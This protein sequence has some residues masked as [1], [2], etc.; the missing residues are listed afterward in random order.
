MASK[1]AS[2]DKFDPGFD[3]RNLITLISM[4]IL[5]ITVIFMAFEAIVTS[6]WPKRSNLTS[7]FNSVMSILYVP[8]RVET[9]PEISDFQSGPAIL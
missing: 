5:F 4:Y 9:D 3:I 7:V 2:E 8:A 1:L 6:K